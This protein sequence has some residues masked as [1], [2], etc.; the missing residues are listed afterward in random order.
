MKKTVAALLLLLTASVYAAPDI[1]VQGVQMPAW[2]QRGNVT[3]PLSV[4]MA[5]RDGD[6]LVTGANARILLSSADGSAIKL[7][8]NAGL[9]ISRL[10]QKRRKS[11]LFTALLDVAKGA[12]RFTTGIAAKL[13]PRDVTVRIANATVGIRGTDVWG[14]VGGKMSITAMEKAMGKS[15]SDSDKQAKMDFDVVCLIEGRIS[16]AHGSEPAF[17]MDQPQTFYVMRKDAAPYPVAA[18]ATEQLAKWAAETEI[19]AGQGAS[20]AGGK[21]KVLLLTANSRHDAMAVYDQVRTAGYDARLRK[22]QD[23]HYQ[24]RIAHLPSRVEAQALADK[25]AGKYGINAPKVVR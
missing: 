6:R 17:V 14:K 15:L 19:A 11:G 18:L 3:R 25:L 4:G 1:V 16:V 20:R 8:E 22:L 21:W 13:R 10:A 7:G 12:F 24:L 9:T 23:G 2:L 5:L